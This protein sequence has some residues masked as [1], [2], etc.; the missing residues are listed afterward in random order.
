M[1]NKGINLEKSMTNV[2]QSFR[3]FSSRSEGLEAKSSSSNFLEPPRLQAVNNPIEGQTTK[4]YT[5]FWCKFFT[6]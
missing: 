3:E 2:Q 6:E 4:K 1:E 5:E